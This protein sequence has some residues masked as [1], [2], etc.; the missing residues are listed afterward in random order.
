LWFGSEAGVDR[1]VGTD[2]R[3]IP[4]VDPTCEVVRELLIPDRT[5]APSRQAGA[6]SYAADQIR[7]DSVYIE[8]VSLIGVSSILRGLSVLSN[9]II[10]TA[11]N[12]AA[13]C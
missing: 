3:P 2:V 8:I 6:I 5:G 7:Q 4:V 10:G 9:P 1:P 11:I 12:K 13:C